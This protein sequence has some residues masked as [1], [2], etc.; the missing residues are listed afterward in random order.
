[1]S[2]V[3]T[4][5]SDDAEKALSEHLKKYDGAKIKTTSEAIKVGLRKLA[6]FEEMKI[7]MTGTR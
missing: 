5:I 6:E 4:W 2:R 7:Q 1:M 3:Q